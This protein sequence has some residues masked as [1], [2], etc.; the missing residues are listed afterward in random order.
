MGAMA[1]AGYVATP[2]S[3][4]ESQRSPKWRA[5]QP[6]VRKVPAMSLGGG[7]QQALLRM[8]EESMVTVNHLAIKLAGGWCRLL[9]SCHV[10]QLNISSLS[11]CAEETG[12]THAPC[13]VFL[14]GDTSDL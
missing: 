6:K 2:G 3:L 14:T 12:I 11:L 9:E 8:T 13:F 5:V 1:L 7:I 4:S 10:S